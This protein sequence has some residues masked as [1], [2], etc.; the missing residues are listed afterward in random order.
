M[1]W[2]LYYFFLSQT[3]SKIL[4]FIPFDDI[5][6]E[7]LD[8][9]PF[10][11]LKDASVSFKREDW[12]Y[13]LP[14][15]WSQLSKQQQDQIRNSI[16]Q[17]N[18]PCTTETCNHIQSSVTDTSDHNGWSIEVFLQ[19][20]V[21]LQRLRKEVEGSYQQLS[22]LE[23]KRYDVLDTEHALLLKI[24][25]YLQN[26]IILIILNNSDIKEK[27]GHLQEQ[28]NNRTVLSNKIIKVRNSTEEESDEIQI[29]YAEWEKLDPIIYHTLEIL[30]SSIKNLLPQTHIHLYKKIMWLIEYSLDWRP[31][32]KKLFQLQHLIPEASLQKESL[33]SIHI[34][35]LLIQ[36]ILMKKKWN[37]LQYNLQE[38]IQEIPEQY[39]KQLKKIIHLIVEN[40]NMT[41]YIMDNDQEYMED[42]EHEIS[43]EE[44]MDQTRKSFENEHELST[45][46]D[47]E[48]ETKKNEYEDT[49]IFTNDDDSESEDS[50]TE[51]SLP[52]IK[53]SSLIFTNDD[54]SESEDSITELSLPTIKKVSSSPTIKK[55]KKTEQVS[56]NQKKELSD[57]SPIDKKNQTQSTQ[58]KIIKATKK[59]STRGT[60]QS[61]RILKYF[62]I[63]MAA[64][65]VLVFLLFIVCCCC[66]SKP[67]P[68]VIDPK[69]NS[70]VV[71][72]A[73][74]GPKGPHSNAS[75]SQS[76][77]SSNQSFWNMTAKDQ[78]NLLKSVD[79]NGNVPNEAHAATMNSTRAP[80]SFQINNLEEYQKAYSKQR[81]LE[82]SQYSRSNKAPKPGIMD[83]FKNMTEESLTEDDII[84]E[85]SNYLHSSHNNHKNKSFSKLKGIKKMIPGYQKSKKIQIVD[86]ITQTY[87][88]DHHTLME[89]QLELQKMRADHGRT[90]ADFDKEYWKAME[91]VH[92]RAINQNIFDKNNTHETNKIFNNYN[93]NI[94][95]KNNSDTDIHDKIFNNN[96]ANF[97]VGELF[98]TPEQNQIPPS[99]RELNMHDHSDDSK[100]VIMYHNKYR[101]SKDA[102]I[103]LKKLKDRRV[104]KKI[105]NNPF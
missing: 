24:E 52:T 2:F 47:T 14:I 29:L 67:P 20:Y 32:K 59:E 95:N 104:Q 8:D 96:I 101:K 68:N 103:G 11:F 12:T 9:V 63:C 26:N 74:R 27:I 36:Y 16:R 57:T 102:H 7:P 23:R 66:F 50:I 4:N 73:T 21:H 28:N 92:T 35:D 72:T 42:S 54:D 98:R 48:D 17:D 25:L 97:S 39:F 89:R 30:S 13:N 15:L 22:I 93:K 18:V 87:E 41:N 10:D 34:Y 70:D 81:E 33:S 99:S 19:F 46:S 37:R 38:E 80:I 56:L 53:N 55:Q 88:P 82:I 105:K 78:I 60:S 44:D 64:V 6:E 69:D 94:N 91:E 5:T 1:K 84:M 3:Q 61:M 31:Q 40:S 62:L 58:K 76:K 90:T 65:G 45:A 100:N 83:F 85:T 75:Q 51:L 86:H 43:T 77:F 79:E 71:P 49:L